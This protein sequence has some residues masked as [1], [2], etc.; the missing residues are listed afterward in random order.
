MHQNSRACVCHLALGLLQLAAIRCV[1]VPN[2]SSSASIECCCPRYL[3][4]RPRYSH[5]TPVLIDLHW[6]PIAFRV[7]FK[8]AL[9]VFKALKGMA[10]SYLIE[11]LHAKTPGRYA[12][13]GDSQHLFTAPRT[14]CRTFGD[15]SFAAAGPKVWNSLPLAIRECDSLSTFKTRLKTF[16]FPEAFE[17]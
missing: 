16:L 9:I 2:G 11:L 12:L 10:P 6:L 17:H 13:R 1:L 14:K 3:P 15:R 7:K 8:I 5:I 4:S